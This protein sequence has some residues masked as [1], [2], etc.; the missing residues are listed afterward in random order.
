MERL[1]AFF[2]SSSDTIE[3]TGECREVDP[4]ELREFMI[5]HGL[6]DEE[7]DVFIDYL[8]TL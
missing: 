4:E 8:K 5:G 3:E 6:E 2:G 7:I 1:R